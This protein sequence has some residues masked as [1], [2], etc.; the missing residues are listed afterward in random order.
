MCVG[1]GGGGGGGDEKGL[2]G[3]RSISNQLK[4]IAPAPTPS[5]RYFKIPY[6]YDNYIVGG[7]KFVGVKNWWMFFN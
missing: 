4:L 1:G 3:S 5:P 2:F 6:A 7:C